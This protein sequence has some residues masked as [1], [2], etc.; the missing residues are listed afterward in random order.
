MP[1]SAI[2]TN[3]IIY[4]IVTVF[5]ILLIIYEKK[6]GRW[7]KGHRDKVSGK[8]VSRFGFS[9]NKGVGLGIQVVQ[10]V[11]IVVMGIYINSQVGLNRLM[12]IMLLINFIAVVVNYKK[13]AMYATLFVVDIIGILAAIM[14]GPNSNYLN[15]GNIGTDSSWMNNS[16]IWML[17]VFFAVNALFFIVQIFAIPEAIKKTIDIVEAIITAVVLVLIIQHFYIG[18]FLVPTTSM[19]PTIQP[20]DRMFANMIEYKFIAPKRGEVIIFKE[21]MTNKENFTK[22]IIGLPGD[23]VHI[24]S[25][26][27]VYIN[28]QPLTGALYNRAY[29]QMGALGNGTWV[30]PKKGDTIRLEGGNFTL[31]G[32][33]LNANT[34]NQIQNNLR[35]SPAVNEGIA[36]YGTWILNGNEITGPCLDLMWDKKTMA[37]LEAGKTITLTH[38][39]YFCMGDNSLDSLDSRYWGFVAQPR[40]K[41]SIFFKFFPIQ[42]MGIVR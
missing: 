16:G 25:D 40:I 4:I 9:M 14:F 29:Y 41:G 8:M 39:Y 36:N 27:H 26:G 31:L 23:S 24:G 15:L 11:F 35:N 6:I 33:P 21:P 34:M 10:A 20:Q 13:H 38:N 7:I 17:I 22:R 1:L 3:A 2:I 32:Q 18:N 19:V 42:D 30:V 12:L 5:F 28:G 37:E